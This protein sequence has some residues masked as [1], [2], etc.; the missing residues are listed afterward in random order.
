MKIRLLPFFFLFLIISCT[1]LEV[2]D[3]NYDSLLV[4]KFKTLDSE[5]LIVDTIVSD[6]TLYGIREGKS[7]SLLYNVESTSWLELPLDPHHTFSRFVLNIEEKSDTL[8]MVHSTGY[9]LISY[10]CGYGALFNLDSMIYGGTM[11]YGDTII[12]SV[13]DAELE[14]YEE[15][16]WIYF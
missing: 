9:Y 11:F 16:I 5:E 8:H 4:I 3:D 15:H 14:Q 2:C 10:T 13:I 12:N 7:D 1:T 6:V